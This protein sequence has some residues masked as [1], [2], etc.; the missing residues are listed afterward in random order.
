MNVF[1]RETSGAS[2]N[3]KELNAE[4]E[5]GVVTETEVATETEALQPA[6]ALGGLKLK[7]SSFQYTGKE[8]CPSVVVMDENGQTVNQKYYEVTYKNNTKVGNAS[9]SVS[10]CDDY[11]DLYHGKLSKTFKIVPS[12]PK[13]LEITPQHSSFSVKWKKAEGGISGY[14]IAYSTGTKLDGT[15][16][17]RKKYSS[18]VQKA[19]ISKLKSGQKYNVWIRSYKI[20][21]EK[22]FY[23][24]W[25]KMK[26][27]TTTKYLIAID[28]GH[29][30]Y[31]NSAKEPNGPGSSTMKAKVTGGA[32]GCVTGQTEY[33]LNLAVAKKL[34]KE[35]KGR[36][37]EVL[38][39]RKSNDVNISNVER[40][41]IANKAGADAFIRI[42]ANGSD[43]ASVNGAMT[44]CQTSRNSYCKATYKQSKA[45]SASVLDHVVSRTGCRRDK[46]WETDTMTGINWCQIP[47]TIIEMGYLSNPQEDRKLATDVYRQKIALGIADGID[48]FLSK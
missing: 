8:I 47:V 15:N 31:G 35:L 13:I 37:Y 29:Q 14:Q 16:V 27:V 1:A 32:Q 23:S 11:A 33:E 22:K 18:S 38:M 21:N 12:K 9:V 45:L 43:S 24:E 3:E 34:Q 17:K 4:I 5:T 26:S 36:G 20:V 2:V 30:R 7:T 46:I 39:I 10:I 28:A 40:A 6:L 44:I 41:Q 19:D 48:E 42:H 25:S